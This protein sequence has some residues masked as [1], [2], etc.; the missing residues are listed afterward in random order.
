MQQTQRGD[1][2]VGGALIPT[3][4]DIYLG[5]GAGRRD[6]V[7]TATM[8]DM[9]EANMV[10][11]RTSPNKWEKTHIIGELYSA[12]QQRGC[13]FVRF[14]Q[15]SGLC[16]LATDR[17]AKNKLGHC[18]RYHLQRAEEPQPEDVAEEDRNFPPGLDIV[19]RR[20]QNAQGSDEFLFTEQELQSVLGQPGELDFPQ[21]LP[22]TDSLFDSDSD[23]SV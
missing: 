20:Q 23:S 8:H 12:L 10:L 16:F 17:E 9:I 5:R 21:Y 14:E 1:I 4:N 13:R 7:G 6:L 11:Y 18:M 15:A 3:E 22:D 19:L 2:H